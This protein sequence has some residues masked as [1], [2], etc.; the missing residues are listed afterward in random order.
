MILGFIS[1]EGGGRLLEYGCLANKK[2]S[3]FHNWKFITNVVM[4]GLLELPWL[5]L[6]YNL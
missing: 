3:I 5:P 6:A 1:N 4:M 2:F